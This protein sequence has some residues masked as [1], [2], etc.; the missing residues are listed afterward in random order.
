MEERICLGCRKI[1]VPRRKDQKYCGK[2]K[3]AKCAVCGNEFERKCVSPIKMTCSRKCNI[4]YIKM[5]QAESAKNETRKCKFCGKEF[6]PTSSRQVYCEGPHYGTCV[7]CGKEYEIPDV[8]RNDYAKTCSKECRDEL[9]RRNTDYSITAEHVRDTMQ[10]KYGVSNA[11]ELPSS[12]DKIVA[13]NKERYGCD[14]Y[15]QTEEYKQKVRETSLEKYGVE[16]PLQAKAVIAKRKE[17]VQKKYGVDNVFQSDEIKETIKN[18]L[19]QRYGVSAPLQNPDAVNKLR[20]TSIQRY[21]A[22]HYCKTD[23]FKQRMVSSNRER[24]GA[25]YY[26]Q[27]RES[28]LSTMSHPSKVDIYLKFREDPIGF[29]SN[30]G[31]DITL[32][33]RW[34]TY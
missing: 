27:T 20:E 8:T 34:G 14:Y 13:T 17:T 25:D 15:T 11:M 1:F 24:F 33:T 7:V 26:T 18:T 16:H 10:E 19:Q 29:L 28:L 22:D 6:H 23:E 2:V 12:K 21:R 3:L 5:K 4:E 9:T 30:F 31:D 32:R